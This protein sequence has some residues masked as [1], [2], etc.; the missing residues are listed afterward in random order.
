MKIEKSEWRKSWVPFLWRQNWAAFY[1]TAPEVAFIS[2][3]NTRLS[4][5][6]PCDHDWKVVELHGDQRLVC[7][8]RYIDVCS[9]C[10]RSR[11]SLLTT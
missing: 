5:G 1:D 4:I 7:D 11:K 3:E 8:A 2:G 10:K 6:K 9:T